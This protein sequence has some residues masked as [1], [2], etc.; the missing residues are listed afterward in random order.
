MRKIHKITNIAPILILIGVFVLSS[1][2]Y[3]AD[4]SRDTH[5]RV[6]L[7]HSPEEAA[8]E[9]IDIAQIGTLPT[10]RL[11]RLIGELDDKEIVALIKDELLHRAKR[12]TYP[13]VKTLI[14]FLLDPEHIESPADKKCS[15]TSKELLLE[16]SKKIKT[17][18]VA[19]SLTRKFADVK[20]KEIVKELLL[21]IADS[22][23][24]TVAGPLTKALIDPE[25][26]KIAEELL[27]EISAISETHLS[28]V[29]KQLVIGLKDP[30]YT[31]SLAD[32]K[33]VEIN[34]RLIL[35]ISENRNPFPAT[36][37]LVRALGY[38]RSMKSA[39]EVLLKF[40]ETRSKSVGETL[41]EGLI[42]EEYA[43]SESDLRRAKNAERLL[44]EASKK[45]SKSMAKPLAKALGKKEKVKVVKRLLLEISEVSEQGLFSVRGSLGRVLEVPE[46]TKPAKELFLIVAKK[47]PEPAIKMMAAG[48]NYLKDI[49]IAK[50][51]LLEMAKVELDLVINH[52][53]YRLEEDSRPKI[54][55][56]ATELLAI[57]R[58][59]T[60]V[61]V[62]CRNKIANL[63]NSTD[64]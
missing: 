13:A 28:A 32:R 14:T 61:V 4:I 30:D 26:A 53:E 56:A 52:L 43:E 23:P 19:N 39:E 10:D 33:R 35:E 58:P 38:P 29:I 5:L 11:I 40:L 15:E 16:I 57:I 1:V 60:E 3:A 62:S 22:Y 7:M 54:I 12:K 25:D 24:Y 6:P 63:P 34:K 51:L 42:D 46:C 55:E 59:A 31:I 47:D 27:F 36:K 37:S 8:A 49:N 18:L 20:R 45:E 2:L 48:L 21:D 64:L 17:G 41:V 9:R 50:E 44:L